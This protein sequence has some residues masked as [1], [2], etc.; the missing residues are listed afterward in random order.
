MESK[1]APTFMNAV[2]EEEEVLQCFYGT[3]LH[4]VMA[5]KV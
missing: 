2:H 5:R 3:Q 4:E 1:A